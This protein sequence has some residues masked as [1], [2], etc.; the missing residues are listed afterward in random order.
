MFKHSHTARARLSVVLPELT[1]LAI[2]LMA[3]ITFLPMAL[4]QVKVDATSGQ[5]LKLTMGQGQIL[6]FDQPVESVFLA[7]TAIADVRVVSPGAV[8]IYGTKVGSTNLIAL[9][10]DQG[11]RGTLQIR[12]VGSPM[13]AQQ[14]AKA[15]QPTTTVDITLFGDQ[16]VGKGHTKN[17][18]EA[19]DTSNVLKSYSKPDKPAL[20]NTTISGP[21]QV[22]IRVRFAEVARNELSRYGLDWSAF[23]NAGSFSF[24]VV[25]TGNT[26]SEGGGGTA[27]GA[28][29][30]NVNVNVLLDALQ[31]NGILTIL[32]EPNI[33]AVTGQ[34]ASF[35]AGGE[36][37]IPVPAGN[38]QIAIE[39][40]Q[41]GVSLQFTPTLLPNDRIALQVRPEVSSV[42]Q[43]SVV[44]INGLV[45]PSLRV[46]RA[47]T[48]VEV[49]S[50]QTFAI[51]GLFQRQETQSINKTPMIGDVPILGELFKSKRFQR[52]ETELVILITPYLV[53]PTSSRSMKTPLDSPSGTTASPRKKARQ[54]INKEY[55]FYV[56]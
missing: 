24:G 13:E 36:I 3:M 10:P 16:F 39:Y 21:N 42:S 25:R 8:Y 52:N 45:V 37:P 2:L 23:F 29:G 9:S 43:D 1:F 11:T 49:G 35:L 17:V 44:S 32:A 4:A 34:T 30:K 53:T 28:V 46:R 5:V 55:G 56:E 22:N 38:Q 6:R 33:T 48:T 12:V 19:V 26:S 54:T 27:I 40:K 15:L 47:D 20:N 50:G 18:G 14:S 51:A 41:F 7:D 31:S